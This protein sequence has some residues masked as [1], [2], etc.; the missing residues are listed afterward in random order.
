MQTG[1]IIVFKRSNTFFSRVISWWTKSQYTHVGVA[2]N[3][4]LCVIE[5]ETFGVVTN[6]LKGRSFV[7]LRTVK[8]ID[9]RKFVDFIRSKLGYGYSWTE[10]F[11]I[12]LKSLF[13]FRYRIPFD[14][15]NEYTCT[16]LPAEG[17]EQLFGIKINK[18]REDCELSPQ[19]FIDSPELKRVEDYNFFD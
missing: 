9:T 6:A 4:P 7:A 8:K 11:M 18:K 16:E 1:D 17:L 5:A 3:F 10:I 12:G 15:K 19:D 13:R 14:W 2:S